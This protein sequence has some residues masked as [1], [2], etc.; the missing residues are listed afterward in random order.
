MSSAVGLHWGVWTRSVVLPT[1]DLQTLG[2]MRWTRGG[3]RGDAVQSVLVPT[4]LFPGSARPVY[5][6][7]TSLHCTS[8]RR[9]CIEPDMGRNDLFAAHAPGGES[10]YTMFW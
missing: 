2:C 6:G 7:Y 3:H 5:N 4:V 9:P 10:T 1:S 8:G